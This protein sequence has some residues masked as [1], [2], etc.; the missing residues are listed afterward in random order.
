M[1]PKKDP[2]HPA[3]PT[4]PEDGAPAPPSARGSGSELPP[5]T[6]EELLRVRDRD[7]A[8]LGRFFDRY[9]THV[10]GLV[11]RLLRDETMAEDA[12]QEVFLKVHR[13]I[14]RLDPERD[15]A[16]WLTTIAYNVCR[17]R[18]RSSADKMDR[19]S[20]SIEDQPGLSNRLGD[21][22]LT[23]EENTLV[24]ERQKLVQ[25]AISRLPES[26]REVVVLHDYEGLTHDEIAQMVGASHAAI[27][28]R[29]SRALSALAD[30]L[31]ETLG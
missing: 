19:Q 23:P 26:Q 9:F 11:Q 30:L 6:R 4:V 20:S 10:F 31:K 12:T 17:D 1:S 27:R 5:P 22:G 2:T 16:P 8:A 25:D 29:Y 15:P 3:G 14:D 21:S 18:W 13:A 24:L 28:K 7:E